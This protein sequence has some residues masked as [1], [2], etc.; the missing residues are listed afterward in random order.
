MHQ[1]LLLISP[2]ASS[3]VANISIEKIASQNN[4]ANYII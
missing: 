3:S 1:V 4:S 2:D